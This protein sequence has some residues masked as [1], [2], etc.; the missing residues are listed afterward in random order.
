[1][2][3]TGEAAVFWGVGK[4]FELR[5]FPVPDPAPGAIVIKVA[6]ANICGSDL[7]Y[8][9]GDM[10]VVAMGRPLPLVLGHEATGRVHKLGAGVTTDSTGQPLREGDRVVYKY[11]NPCGH[12]PACLRR[13]YKSC[14]RRLSNWWVSCEEWPHFQGAFGQYYYLRPNHAVF[15]VPDELSDEMVAGVNC[16]LTQ[17]VAGFEIAGLRAGETVVIQGAGGLGVYAAAVAKEAGAHR[18]VVIDGVDERLALARAFGADHLVDLREY[19]EAA[20]RIKV[21]QQL[22]DDWGGD[23]VVELVGNPA[24]MDEGIRMTAP[25]GRYLEIGN[26]N[27]G[28]K[29][30]IDPSLLVFGNRKIVGVS[31]YE[32]EHLKR[33][34]DFMLRTRD[35]YPYDRV[36]SHKFP[37]A[38]INE[39]CEQQDKG[40]ITRSAVVPN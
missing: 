15:K 11:M 1:M 4:P 24:V 19:P 30:S 29:G 26:I 32:G 37:L 18:V 10:D 21:V 36:L 34:L 31:H 28:W 27:V 20:D 8:W 35:R 39:A 38:Q 6:L 9:R 33:A 23:V 40:Y 25:E 14:P 7:H 22:C 16:A 5:E 2:P 12:C 3:E 13:Q 17:V